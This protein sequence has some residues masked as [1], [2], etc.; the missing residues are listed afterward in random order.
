CRKSR[1]SPRI[2]TI[3]SGVA[4]PIVTRDGAFSLSFAAKYGTPFGR[5]SV[6]AGQVADGYRSRMSGRFSAS[7]RMAT[8]PALT[9]AATPATPPPWLGT[10]GSLPRRRSGEG[11]DCPRPPGGGRRPPSPPPRSPPPR[12]RSRR[13]REGLPWHPARRVPSTGRAAVG[14]RRLRQ[15]PPR[16][17]R[18]PRSRARPEACVSWRTNSLLVAQERPARGENENGEST[19]G[20]WERQTPRLAPFK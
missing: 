5:R 19:L 2:F 20:A 17:R 10:R 12:S 6:T 7:T 14:P 1:A 15:G 13:W 16:C 3:R 8:H 11:G 9:A 4:A 18:S